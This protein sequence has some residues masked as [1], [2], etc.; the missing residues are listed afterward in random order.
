MTRGRLAAMAFTLVAVCWG[1]QTAL[2]PVV[3][4]PVS[5]TVDLPAELQPFL[6]VS[7]HAKLQGYVER[8]VVDRGSSV[9]QGALIA[10]LSAPELQ[11]QLAEAGSK[12]QAADA[13]RLQAEAQLAA[14]E[15]TFERLKKAGETPGAVAGNELTQ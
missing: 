5:R 6:N 4:R 11:A 7:L 10:Q 15:S 13:E 12:V 9:K 14:V 2:A 1:Q 8:I 3:A